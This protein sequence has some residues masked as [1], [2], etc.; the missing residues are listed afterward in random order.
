M[1]MRRVEFRNFRSSSTWSL[2]ISGS[3]VAA[4]TQ[5]S[6]VAQFSVFVFAMKLAAHDPRTTLLV[7]EPE[8]SLHPQAGASR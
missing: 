7:Q 3:L 6:G 1:R 8:I 4:A 5:S 2:T